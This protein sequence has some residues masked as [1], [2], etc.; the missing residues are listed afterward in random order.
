MWHHVLVIH[1]AIFPPEYRYGAMAVI[2][3]ETHT[4]HL[5]HHWIHSIPHLL[6][7]FRGHR[8]KALILS[9]NWLINSVITL[10]I[11]SNSS[12]LMLR[13]FR[14]DFTTMGL[15]SLFFIWST[16]GLHNPSLLHTSWSPLVL[17]MEHPIF[18]KN[19]LNSLSFTGLYPFPIYS[20][21]S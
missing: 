8:H 7:S 14:F 18:F 10:I 21:H 17:S 4:P 20:G 6:P 5:L 13:V 2:S 11:C 9:Y 1:P 19:A 3:N 12:R 15:S 16:I